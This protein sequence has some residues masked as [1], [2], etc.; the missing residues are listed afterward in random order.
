[1]TV[2]EKQ[3]P[4]LVYAAIPF[5]GAAEFEVK[6]LDYN[7][8]IRGSLK[9]GIMQRKMNQSSSQAAI[10]KLS[11]HRDNSCIWFKSIFK[12]KTEFQNNMGGVHMLR[13]Y[14]WVNLDE[15]KKDD[16]MGLQLTL[17]GDLS[18]FVNGISQ[19][20]AAECIYKEGYDVFCFIELVEGCQAIEVT[21][22]GTHV[23]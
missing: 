16:R 22:A 10:P 12:Q 6:L 5:R 11:E 23:V 1:M 3:G 7:I 18:F 19:G 15:L 21:R 2:D 8:G 9:L 14:G 4:G 17:D 20:L 13:H